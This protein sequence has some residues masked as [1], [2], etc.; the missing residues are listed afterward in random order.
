MANKFPR[1]AAQA[2]APQMT[3]EEKKAQVARFLQQKRE[4]FAI[5]ILC[6]LCRTTS[7]PSGLVDQAVTMADQLM[8]KLY[9]MPEESGK[10]EGEKKEEKVQKDLD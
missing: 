2:Q 1:P 7:D 6:N 4:G 8:D 9:P 3:E 10:K 5:N